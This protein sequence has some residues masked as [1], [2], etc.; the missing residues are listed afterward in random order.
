LTDRFRQVWLR[1]KI[2]FRADSG[3]CR[4]HMF[5]W[6]DKNDVHYIVGIAQNS[7]LKKQAAPLLE[8][9]LSA[10]MATGEKARLFG[11]IVKST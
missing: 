5:N 10:H 7:R 4:H 1:V 9:A 3:F 11:D 8:A 2:V 6:C